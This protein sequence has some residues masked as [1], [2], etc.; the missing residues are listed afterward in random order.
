L[1]DEIRKATNANFISGND[2]FKEDISKTMGRHVN[3]GEAGRP[4]KDEK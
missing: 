2:L 1:V 4:V 3:P